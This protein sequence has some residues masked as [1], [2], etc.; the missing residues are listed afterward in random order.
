[1]KLRT[2]LK[3][4]LA[5]AALFAVPRFV[6]GQQ[7]TDYGQ[8]TM[9]YG[10]GAVDSCPFVVDNLSNSCEK[11][12]EKVKAFVMGSLVTCGLIGVI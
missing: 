12:I 8:Q 11:S 7:T 2:F 1:M 5:G 3:G 10:E 4:C 6:S 9:E